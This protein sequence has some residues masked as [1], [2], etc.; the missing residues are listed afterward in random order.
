MIFLFDPILLDSV[1]QVL[2]GIIP[3]VDRGR[4]GARSG[5]VLPSILGLMES[6]RALLALT[7]S[8]F[9]S[10]HQLPQATSPMAP[11]LANPAAHI[12]R[13]DTMI[14]VGM[15]EP[16][17]SKALM[18]DLDF[19]DAEVKS[20]FQLIGEKSVTILAEQAKQNRQIAG[21]QHFAVSAVGE[22]PR[23]NEQLTERGISPFRVLDPVLWGM[24]V[25]GLSL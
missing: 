13:D 23:H 7:V 15:Q 5:E 22:S 1:R 20:L 25:R 8:K 18:E 16:A 10:L 17:S 12:N 11:A 19:L 9:D 14:L 2:S 3:D 4:L 21:Y 24:Q 6:G